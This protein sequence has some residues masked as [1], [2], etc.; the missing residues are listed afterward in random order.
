MKGS[1]FT[2][3]K[4]KRRNVHECGAEHEAQL[5]PLPGL[6]PEP[7]QGGEGQEEDV[8]VEDD[9]EGPL[10]DDEGVDVGEGRAQE[11]P[12]P[13]PTATAG[14]VVRAEDQVRAVDEH[15]AGNAGRDGDPQ[16]LVDG[17]Y[18][19]QEEE[20]GGL[21][22]HVREGPQYL[23]H[24]YRLGKKSRFFLC[25]ADRCPRVRFFF[26]LVDHGCNGRKKRG[27]EMHTLIHGTVNHVSPISFLCRT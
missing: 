25:S 10:L 5:Q 8:Q 23:Q 17:E 26:L 18:A 9:A 20:D 16:R 21:R 6:Q 11:A 24:E 22:G 19:Q 7:R 2:R 4:K 3:K 12:A 27:D 15:H 13:A 1:A 14:H